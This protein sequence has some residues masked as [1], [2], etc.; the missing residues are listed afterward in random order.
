[1]ISFTVSELSQNKPLNGDGDKLDRYVTHFVRI[2]PLAL[3]ADS[4]VVRVGQTLRIRVCGGKP[5]S[6]VWFGIVGINGTPVPATAISLG[7]FA[8]TGDWTWSVVIPSGGS[9]LELRLQSLT[10]DGTKWLMSNTL[11]VSI[12]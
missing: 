2:R 4:S 8:A 3:T 7:T 6:R 5:G 11:L 1:M 12:L 9:G 10:Y